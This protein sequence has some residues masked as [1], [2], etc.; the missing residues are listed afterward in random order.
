MAGDQNRTT[1]GFVSHKLADYLAANEKMFMG[2]LKYY[3]QS[4]QDVVREDDDVA[5]DEKGSWGHLLNRLFDRIQIGFCTE[6]ST[7]GATHLDELQAS[8]RVMT[9]EK[10]KY[11]TIFE[12]LPFPVFL[13]DARH[14]IGNLNHAATRWLGGHSIPGAHYYAT[15]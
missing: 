8:N 15:R 4:Y 6:W 3:R 9:N 13:L 5:D 10:N 12:S 1:A 14:A 11:L 2:R 7:S